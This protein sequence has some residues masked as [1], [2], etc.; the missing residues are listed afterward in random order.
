MRHLIGAAI[1]ALFA[2]AP[3]AP[4]DA[5]LLTARE[6]R[7]GVFY[8]LRCMQGKR[9]VLRVRDVRPVRVDG[10]VWHVRRDDGR[11]LYVSTADSTCTLDQQR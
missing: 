6:A 1:V 10:T 3:F 11:L 5:K 9:P 4:A 7:E 2:C 8:E